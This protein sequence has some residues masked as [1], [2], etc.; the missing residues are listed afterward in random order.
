MINIMHRSVCAISVSDYTQ[1]VQISIRFSHSYK[2]KQVPNSPVNASLGCLTAINLAVEGMSSMLSAFFQTQSSSGF[3]TD[4][5]KLPVFS[6]G[7]ASL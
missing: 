2:L 7:F 6:S 3:N 5:Q 1:V 4:I